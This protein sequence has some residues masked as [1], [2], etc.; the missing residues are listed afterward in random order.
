[1]AP[2]PSG[3]ISALREGIAEV[4]AAIPAATDGHGQDVVGHQAGG[5]H[6]PRKR[7]PGCR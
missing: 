5:R 7:D 4:I 3:T 1:M 2:N 6:E